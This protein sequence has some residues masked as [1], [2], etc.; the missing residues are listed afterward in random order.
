L[1]TSASGPVG[2]YSLWT[3][4]DYGVSSSILMFKGHCWLPMATIKIKCHLSWYLSYICWSETFLISYS[5]TCPYYLTLLFHAAKTTTAF[6]TRSHRC[7][8]KV[9]YR[10][11]YSDWH[12]TIS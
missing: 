8:W 3:S 10:F 9:Y 7:E 6:S 1:P 5:D 4:I 11:S 12:L 2:I